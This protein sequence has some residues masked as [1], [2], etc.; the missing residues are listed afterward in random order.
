[1]G[2]MLNRIN[3]ANGLLVPEE[4]TA[5]DAEAESPSKRG[6]VAAPAS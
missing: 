3:S 4:D 5:L 1:M 6:V 2:N